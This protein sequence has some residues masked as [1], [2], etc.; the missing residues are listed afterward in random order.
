[1]GQV[2]LGFG[3]SKSSDTFHGGYGSF[4]LEIVHYKNNIL[5]LEL[6]LD[7]SSQNQFFIKVKIIDNIHFPI[8][9]ADDY[10]LIFKKSFVKNIT[11]FQI[12][13]SFTLS[14][15]ENVTKNHT[16]NEIEMFE[17]L[18]NPTKWYLYDCGNSLCGCGGGASYM[19]RGRIAID[20]LFKMKSYDLIEMA[21]F[22]ANPVGRIYAMEKLEE[23]ER[24]Q[25]IAIADSTKL[26]ID[27]IKHLDVKIDLCNWCPFESYLGQFSYKEVKLKLDSINKLREAGLLPPLKTDEDE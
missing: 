15:I 13:S 5:Y 21:V 26:I 11:D 2:D 23:L 27:S 22:S 7:F 1:M 9:C 6:L 18:T 17:Q 4:Y 20:S 16:P 25:K 14:L 19:D 24:N 10:S 3:L 12:E 8:E